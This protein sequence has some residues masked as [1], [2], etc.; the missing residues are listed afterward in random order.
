MAG[1]PWV[2]SIGP[3]RG[4]H[5]SSRGLAGLVFNHVVKYKSLFILAEQRGTALVA[6]TCLVGRA[7][8]PSLGGRGSLIGFRSPAKYLK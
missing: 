3:S 2:A 1:L 7:R 5:P 6:L 4:G 8:L